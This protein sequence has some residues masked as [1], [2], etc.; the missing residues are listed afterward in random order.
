MGK[1]KAPAPPDPRETASAQTGT[2][3]GT[4][5]AN[6]Q[7]QMVD[8]YTPNGSLTYTLRGGGDISDIPSIQE[9]AGTPQGSSTPPAGWSAE[10]DGPYQAPTSA[11][12]FQ[13]GDQTFS[14][15]SEAEQYRN[16]LISDQSGSFYNYTDPFTGQT[17]QIPRYESRIELSEDQ[18]AI[19]DLN[20]DAQINLAGTA[21]DQSSFLRDYLGEPAD[22][23]TQEIE[24]RLDELGRQR[25]DPRFERQENDLRTRL[26]NQGIAPG[27]EAYDREMDRLAYD[28]NDAYNNLYLKGRGQA[29]QELA[30]KRNQPINEITALLSGSQVSQPNVRPITP[31]GAATTDVA[32]IIN[33][34]YKDRLNVWQQE[35]ANRQALMGGLFGA[36]ATLLG[37]PQGS[38]LGGFF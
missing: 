19:N 34:N 21:A 14:S 22:F 8:Q 2:N 30:A 18:Q 31:Q 13:V 36:G 17:Y 6:S 25:L 32:G 33:Q 5:I 20:N 11:P 37:A 29:F 10:N 28:R 27:S 26:A 24:G 23:D 16:N 15:R 7:M 3:I 12:S 35:Q 38:I 9:I 1:P 4:A